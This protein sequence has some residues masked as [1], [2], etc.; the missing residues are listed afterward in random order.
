MRAAVWEIY[1]ISPSF[2]DHDYGQFSL[3]EL[4]LG[5]DPD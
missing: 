5:S 4:E 3:L 1:L 2:I